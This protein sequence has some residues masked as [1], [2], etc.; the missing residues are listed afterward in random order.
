[1]QTGNGGPV[2]PSV[3]VELR[4]FSFLASSVQASLPGGGQLCFR[5]FYIPSEQALSQVE[6]EDGAE[7]AVAAN[8]MRS[9]T[10]KVDIRNE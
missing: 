3:S 7:A 10:D 4:L 1:V 6:R 5:C 2:T 8:S 9:W